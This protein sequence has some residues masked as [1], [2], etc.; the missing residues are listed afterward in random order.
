MFVAGSAALSV[1]IWRQRPLSCSLG[2]AMIL[3]GL[4]FYRR[5][6]REGKPDRNDSWLI[7]RGWLAKTN[8]R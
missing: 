6:R 2:L 7:S 5:W 8:I 4:F 3:A 1:S